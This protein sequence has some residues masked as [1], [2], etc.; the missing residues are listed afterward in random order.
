MLSI[1]DFVIFLDIA[2]LKLDE[3][4]FWLNLLLVGFLN[5][6]L[7]DTAINVLKVAFCGLLNMH[8]EKLLKIM[9]CSMSVPANIIFT[10]LVGIVPA[11]SHFL[12][13]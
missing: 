6:F 9:V 13:N 4:Q 11:M 12:F 2:Q 8:H 10:S 7:T 3:R 5:F 1:K